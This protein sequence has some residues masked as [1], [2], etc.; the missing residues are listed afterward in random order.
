MLQV[1]EKH[2][3]STSLRLL[4]FSTYVLVNLVI[5]HI[6]PKTAAHLCVRLLLF[7]RR[8]CLDFILYSLYF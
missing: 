6:T 3:E 4:Y 1:R 7:V 8:D 2:Q 5:W